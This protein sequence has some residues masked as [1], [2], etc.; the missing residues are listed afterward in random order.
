[1]NVKLAVLTLLT[2][3]LQACSQQKSKAMDNT[4]NKPQADS[5]HW[6]KL[7]PEEAYIIVNK[8]T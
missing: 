8:G 3:S 6:R 2:C 4:Q 7:T 1:M 5:T